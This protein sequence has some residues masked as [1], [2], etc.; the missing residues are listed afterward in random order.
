MTMY[1]PHKRVQLQFKGKGRTKQSH[2]D[3]CDV[4]KI[5]KQFH[6]TG[7]IS[8]ARTHRGFYDD[9]I[10]ATDYKS[11]LDMIREADEMFMTIPSTIRKQFD[12]DPAKF[13]DFVQDPD[14]REEMQAMGLLKVPPEAA[15][16]ESAAS[17]DAASDPPQSESGASPGEGSSS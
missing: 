12:N 6:K 2:K 1:R 11:A 16:A 3:E 14:N 9:F 5:I 13:L 17:A 4:N 8:H 10:G 15:T 7:M